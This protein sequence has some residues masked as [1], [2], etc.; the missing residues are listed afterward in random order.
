MI[1]SMLILS[2]ARSFLRKRDVGI[3]T[4]TATG[5]WLLVRLLGGV[6]LFLVRLLRALWLFRILGIF[7]LDGLL[8]FVLL[9]RGTVALLPV[10]LDLCVH[11]PDE[12]VALGGVIMKDRQ[13]VDHLHQ[14]DIGSV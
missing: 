7:R 13:G 11:K 3:A 9:F 12:G 4:V 1:Y 10:V 2:S 14:A 5:L 8:G 6:G